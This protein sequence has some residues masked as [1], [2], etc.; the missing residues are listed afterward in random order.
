MLK[1][2]KSHFK[3]LPTICINTFFEKLNK[4][5]QKII[6]VLILESKVLSLP[7]FVHKIFFSQKRVL[8]P[9]FV[10]WILTP[11]KKKLKKK[12][13][14]ATLRKRHHSQMS[15]QTERQRW[16]HR[17]VQQGWGSIKTSNYQWYEHSKKPAE[18]FSK[19]Q[20]QRQII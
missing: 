3:H 5:T 4:F 2:K 7:Y 1:F 13:N 8:S 15:E 10:Y 9:F 12:I 11:C 17:K 14:D 16:I 18:T 19:K 20:M 6:K